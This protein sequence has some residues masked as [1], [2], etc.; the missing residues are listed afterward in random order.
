MDVL[1]LCDN[2][3][4][5]ESRCQKD[6]M[7][8]SLAFF[9]K[10]Y[11]KNELILVDFAQI[12]VVYVLQGALKVFICNDFGAEKLLYYVVEGCSCLANHHEE[13]QVYL[14]LEAGVDC[15][16]CFVGFFSLMT[17]ICEDKDS[18]TKMLH[19]ISQQMAAIEANLLDLASCSLKGRI[20]KFI[21]ALAEQ[22]TL[23]TSDG[24]VILKKF[25][26]RVDIA[27]FTGIRKRNVIKCLSELQEQGIIRKEGKRMII[28]DFEQLK[29]EIAV[30]CGGKSERK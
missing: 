23:F 11:R 6:Q 12:A 1:Y 27:R 13:E 29:A 20:C 30:G 22:S 24:A 8:R 2:T 3:L 14:R 26:S 17:H 4:T 10:S 28:V 25:P 9:E 15:K 16:V 7:M 21:A 19:M 18:F 5:K